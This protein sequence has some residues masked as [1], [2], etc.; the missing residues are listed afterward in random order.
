MFTLKK[1]FKYLMGD[2]YLTRLVFKGHEYEE[3]MYEDVNEIE[4]KRIL[5]MLA[6]IQVLY[7]NNNVKDTVFANRNYKIVENSTVDW[8]YELFL[9][10]KA[11]LYNSVYSI[12]FNVTPIFNT[13]ANNILL[14]AM[15]YEKIDIVR[16]FLNKR[17]FNINDSIFG[18][19]YWPSYYMFSCACSSS[20]HKLFLD[21]YA[22]NSVFW[23]GL[24]PNLLCAMT[25]KEI[26]PTNAFD[27]ISYNEYMLIN[28]FR[29]VEVIK[30]NKNYPLFTID[31]V[32]I[33]KH[34]QNLRELVEKVPEITSLSYLS[35]VL[36]NYDHFILILTRYGFKPYQEFNGIT[37]MHISTKNSSFL[38]M[39]YLV[40]TGFYIMED[41]KGNF[42]EEV[43]SEAIA[44]RVRKFFEICT[45]KLVY[46]PSLKKKVK[47]IWVSTISEKHKEIKQLLED[48]NDK[49]TNV[50][51]V[52][53]Y[54]KYNNENKILSN[55]RFSITSI[56][57]KTKTHT[58][59]EQDTKRILYKFEEFT[60]AKN[61][62]VVKERYKNSFYS[63]NIEK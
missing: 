32:C 59:I 27:F 20:I 4:Q 33:N 51:S 31:F 8:D 12:N 37:P 47:L 23:G 62:N 55:S 16:Y 15:V 1:V 11:I 63:K 43:A 24:S 18:S 30:A 19:I 48:S 34:T 28:T 42:P 49:K 46:D 41:S 2:K 13:F 25:N 44:E 7:K 52:L 38:A 26:I 17:L 58:Q 40:Y 54:L 29:G 35:F 36:Q 56:F 9:M 22:I 5:L 10:K 57:S 21:E 39:V 61:E 14:L 53:K 45:K 3:F 60:V 6:K 50:W